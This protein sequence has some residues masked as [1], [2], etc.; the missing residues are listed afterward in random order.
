MKYIAEWKCQ[1]A[2]RTHQSRGLLKVFCLMEAASVLILASAIP[3][4]TLIFE[5]L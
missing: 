1:K 4:T 5:Y 2:C 3:D